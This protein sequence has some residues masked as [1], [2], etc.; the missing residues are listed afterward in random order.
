VHGGL[1]KS[2]KPATE[3]SRCMRNALER[4]K[5]AEGGKKKRK[6]SRIQSVLMQYRK[7]G[8]SRNLD[9]HVQDATK[10]RAASGVCGERSGLQL[11]GWNK[12]D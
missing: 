7:K 12:M 4:L 6:I 3:K 11:F 8:T 10:K 5:A 2:E 9:D 1:P